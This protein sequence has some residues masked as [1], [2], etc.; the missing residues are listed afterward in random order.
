MK[1]KYFYMKV[2]E[3]WNMEYFNISPQSEI[4]YEK[5]HAISEDFKSSFSPQGD[6]L[7]DFYK[8]LLDKKEAA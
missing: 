5:L 2:N 3:N 1:W 4:S 6:K 8:A 7:A